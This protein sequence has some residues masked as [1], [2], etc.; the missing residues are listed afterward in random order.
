MYLAL[1]FFKVQI[2]KGAAYIPVGLNYEETEQLCCPCTA[3]QPPV[4]HT[5]TLYKHKPCYICIE[6]RKETL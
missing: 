4:V 5:Y 1:K 6:G 2:I 3:V